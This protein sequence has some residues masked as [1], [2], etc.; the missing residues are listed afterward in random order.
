M[1]RCVGRAVR[2]VGADQILIVAVDGFDERRL[3]VQ[4]NS[5]HDVVVHVE[6]RGEQ[7]LVSRGVS[8]LA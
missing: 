2:V 5:G 3:I 1:L 7:R 8:L 6:A 4:G